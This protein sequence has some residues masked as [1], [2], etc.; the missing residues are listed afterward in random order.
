MRNVYALQRGRMEIQISR[1]G[2]PKTPLDNRIGPRGHIYRPWADH[3]GTV[4]SLLPDHTLHGAQHKDCPLETL[5][6]A[7]MQAANN[8]RISEDW[9]N[10]Y[11]ISRRS[12]V[13]SYPNLKHKQYFSHV[14]C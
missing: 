12:Q 2:R 1:S 11:T 13:G 9:S 3:T 10:G 5:M 14:P 7:V 8:M 4:A 6:S